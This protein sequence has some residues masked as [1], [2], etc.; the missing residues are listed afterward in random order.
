MTRLKGRLRALER[1]M[2]VGKRCPVC[3]Y[4]DGAPVKLIGTLDDVKGSTACA[5]CGRPLDSP[6]AVAQQESTDGTQD[7]ESAR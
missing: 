5:G 2:A 6:R 7:G 4:G 3:G 1:P